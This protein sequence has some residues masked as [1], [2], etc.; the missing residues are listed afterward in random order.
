MAVSQ[1]TVVHKGVQY[2]VEVDT[3]TEALDCARHRRLPRSS[4]DSHDPGRQQRERSPRTDRPHRV[5]TCR[6][7]D[8]ATEQH[9]R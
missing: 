9:P 7:R 5:T 6:D 1:A 2:D 4:N 8:G 3:A